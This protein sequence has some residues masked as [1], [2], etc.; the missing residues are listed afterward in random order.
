MRTLFLKEYNEV[1]GPWAAFT[2][3]KEGEG[4]H[5]NR[6]KLATKRTTIRKVQIL[7]LG[8]EEKKYFGI[9]AF[10]SSLQIGKR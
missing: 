1:C 3:N 5:K 6:E 2:S 7:F 4:T 9:E 8:K 10:F